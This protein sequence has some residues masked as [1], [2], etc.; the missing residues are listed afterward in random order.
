MGRELT[1]NAR[2]TRPS[3]GAPKL[4]FTALSIAALVSFACLA[5]NPGPVPGP[6]PGAVPT[7]RPAP[8]GAAA[9]QPAPQPM[10]EGASSARTAADEGATVES[11]V[12]DLAEENDASPPADKPSPIELTRQANSALDD[13]H[14][15][16]SVGDR[17]RYVAH[18]ALDAVFLGTDRTERWDLAEFTAYVDQYFKPGSGWTY[19]PIE[20]FVTLSSDGSIAWFD[21]RLSSHSYGEVRGTGVLRR[22]GDAWRIVHYSMTFTIPNAVAREVVEVVRSGSR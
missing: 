1:S 11:A 20:R 14:Q 8:G 2:R 9:H 18:F 7:A 6:R 15:A 22:E 16:A 19:V 21:E 12:E 17:D 5:P 10:P 13:W 3:C 4:T